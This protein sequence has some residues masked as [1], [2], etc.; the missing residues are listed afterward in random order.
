MNFSKFQN[1]IPE[2]LFKHWKNHWP[3]ESKEN[4]DKLLATFTTQ[5]GYP[6]V[7]IN[8]NEDGYN[9]TV[10]QKRFLLNVDDGSDV[11]L[12]YMI[13]FTFTTDKELNFNMTKPKTYL[14]PI[15]SEIRV[16]L[17]N[18][19]WVMA[20]IQI[21]GY[22]RV[23]YN[24]QNWK[25]ICHALKES[26]WAN[27]IELNRAQV[28]D[29]LFNLARSGYVTYDLALNC[30]EY[31]TT[32]IDYIPWAA[33]FK[34]YEFLAIRLGTSNKEDFEKYILHQTGKVFK[35]LGFDEKKS[36]S[37]LDVLNRNQVLSWL[38]MFGHSDCISKSLN[39]YKKIASDSVPADIRSVVYCTVVR[40]Q[41]VKEFEFLLNKYKHEKIATEKTVIMKA[42][43]CVK[44]QPLIERYFTIIM[45][46]DIRLQDKSAALRALYTQNF[47]NV[48]PVFKLVTENCDQLAAS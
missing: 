3:T 39:L 10:T 46:D 17:P 28:I 47:E 40:E 45:S 18:V 26:N 36:D 9:M 32:E 27:I 33:A 15:A 20:N 34:G 16:D 12:L 25:K 48:F 2:N 4:V 38:C 11:N 24:E 30:L 5:V 41:S 23:N 13:P 44:D 21:S 37:R 7:Y 29:D 42:L 6:V 1:T 35:H 14:E 19:S 8:V 31:L 22:Y 43:G